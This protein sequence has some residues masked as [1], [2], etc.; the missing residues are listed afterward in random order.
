MSPDAQ[1][2][3]LHSFTSKTLSWDN[4]SIMI[5]R[6]SSTLLLL[7]F[8][9]HVIL[10]NHSSERPFSLHELKKQLCSTCLPLGRWLRRH[11]IESASNL[12]LDDQIVDSS[13][14]NTNL[15]LAARPSY[16]HDI[17]LHE[18]IIINPSY[19]MDSVHHQLTLHI[20]I[21]HDHTHLR[22]PVEHCQLH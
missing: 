13:F 2:C 22:S 6:S 8:N 20:Q 21:I 11:P 14:W 19:S 12:I 7:I 18:P 9:D 10:N 16:V 17:T 4:L 1:H 5:F 3:L 15:E